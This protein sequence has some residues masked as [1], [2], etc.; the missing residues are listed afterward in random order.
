MYINKDLIDFNLD[1]FYNNEF[2]TVN[3]DNLKDKWSI[4]FFYPAN[5]TF[6]CPTELIDLNDH[7]DEFKKIGCEIYSVSTD[8]KFS[9][10][11]WHDM[12]NSINKIRYPMLSDNKRLLSNYFHILDEDD[13]CLRATF[14]INPDLKIVGYEINASNVGRSANEIL[15]K[16]KA[17]QFVYTHS[18]EVCPASWNDSKETLKP[19][20]DLVGKL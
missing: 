19:S 6:V 10:K 9:H 7:Y 12:S 11:A 20:I 13:L 3:N 18:D 16:L 15:R 14:I 4:L 2:I 1:G 8:T 17:F 5:F